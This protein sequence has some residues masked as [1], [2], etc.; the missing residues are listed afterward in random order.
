MSP[1]NTRVLLV[2]DDPAILRL[3]TKW[4]T[5]AEYRVS[6]TADGRQALA[7][8]QRE[9]P[10]FLVTDWEMPHMNGL[11]LCG[12]VRRLDLPHYVYILMLSVR[13]SSGE[14]VAGLE[15]GAD[16]FLTKPVQR[17]EL[18]ARLHSGGRVLELERRLN[19]IAHTDPL[20]GLPTRRA[21]YE[22][23]VKEWRR[24]TRVNL[25]LSCVMVDL[26]FF[27]RIN[28]I[29]GHP[30]GDTVLKAVSDLLSKSCRGSDSICRH[31]GEEFCV[32]LP[33]TNEHGAVLWAERVRKRM[34]S[35]SVAAGSTQLR[36]TASFGAAQRQDD[37][38]TPEELVD[39]AD[40]ALRCAKQSG[41]DRVV[42]FE[43]LADAGRLD[44]EDAD[45]HGDLF[46]G[47]TARHVMSPLVA[48]LREDETVDHAAEYFLR[49]RIGSSPVVDGDGKLVGILSE[50]DIMAA[51]VSLD[52]WRKPVRELMKPNV[53]CYEEATPIRT[54]YEFI[55]RVALR[56][57]VIVKEGRVTGTISR[58]TLVRWVRN[59]VITKGLLDSEELPK[60]ARNL[61][62]HRSQERLAETARELGFQAARLQQCFRDNEETEDLV[63]YVVGGASQMQELVN[64]LLAYSRYANET[65]GGAA[66]IQSMLLSTGHTD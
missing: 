51:L 38:Q 12:A 13:S 26:D 9:C 63:P 30:V 33:E 27:K 11:D 4:L 10:D 14:K 60:L 18:L 3:L 52:W 45:K 59:L 31:G 20:T 1:S 47:V 46:H 56:C 49:L 64:D 8:I 32:M 36:I 5:K 66:A 48:C 21:F 61:D 35:L 57:V 16:E 2:D 62:P 55:C 6:Q 58:G 23:L 19:L 15:V 44:L 28:D 43:A 29:H 41:R 37:T 42:G 7:A 40:Q 65:A 54:I 53:I 25:P 39:Q 22:N 50:K 34:A 17:D 24:A